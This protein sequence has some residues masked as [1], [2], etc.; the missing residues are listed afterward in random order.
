MV[1][2][3]RCGLSKADKKLCKCSCGG[4][5]HGTQAVLD[6]FESSEEKQSKSI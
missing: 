5:K 6:I 4:K 3:L 1:H 2:T